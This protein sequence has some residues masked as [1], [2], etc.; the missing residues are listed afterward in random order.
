VSRLDPFPCTD[1]EFAKTFLDPMVVDAI[2]RLAKFGNLVVDIN[3]TAVSVEVESDL[4]SPRKE[5]A[6]RQFLTDAETII[7]KAAH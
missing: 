6:L 7:E 4:S 3:R 2:I 5:D 1:A